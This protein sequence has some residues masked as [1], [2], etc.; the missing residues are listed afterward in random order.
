MWRPQGHGQL[1]SRARRA[2]RGKTIAPGGCNPLQYEARRNYI[3]YS[4]RPHGILRREMA[5]DVS[6]VEETRATSRSAPAETRAPEH[7]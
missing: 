3:V 6:V 7:E 2:D 5:K 1:F 4:E